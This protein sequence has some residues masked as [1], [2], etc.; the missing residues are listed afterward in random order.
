M[1]PLFPHSL[2]SIPHLPQGVDLAAAGAI[3]PQLLGARHLRRRHAQIVVLRRNGKDM[4]A[5]VRTGLGVSNSG[6]PREVRFGLYYMVGRCVVPGMGGPSIGASLGRVY[7]VE[8]SEVLICGGPHKSIL[9]QQAGVHLY[10]FPPFLVLKGAC[11]NTRDTLSGVSIPLRPSLC[12][13]S[14]RPLQQVFE[15]HVQSLAH[16]WCDQLLPDRDQK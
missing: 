11:Q 12:C 10:F 2:Q 6:A 5:R 7:T 16:L 9:P 14:R 15:P 13:P 4:A 3:A 1:Y 8:L